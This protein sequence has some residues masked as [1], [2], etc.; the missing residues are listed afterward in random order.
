MALFGEKYD[1][2]VRVLRFGDFSV[3]LCGGTHVRR[4]GD[5]GV[6]RIIN[7]GGVAAGVRR[8]EALTGAAALAWLDE[9]EARLEQ[10]AERVKGSRDN[11]V[12]KVDVLLARLRQQD[13]ELQAL[14]GRL[15]SAT[16]A[17]LS[18][19]AVEVGGLKVLAASLE[20]ADV[21]TLRET[22]DQLKNKLGSA[23]LVLASAAEGKVQIVAGV[24]KDSTDRIKAGELANY[25]AAQVGGKGGGRADMA[26]A[27]G[28][29][30][31]QLQAALEGVPDWVREQLAA[32]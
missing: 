3:E 30:P 6:F 16:G 9:S 4:T 28:T 19:Q 24:T 25:V 10:V 21:K 5:I 17:D 26:Q 14:K 18:A 22:V 8:I 29:R 7:E 23:A 31:E 13:K 27:G 15:S 2:Q 11:V 1:E 20:G 12:E 32:G